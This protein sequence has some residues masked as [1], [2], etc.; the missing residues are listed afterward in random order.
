MPPF[1]PIQRTDLIR[2]LRKAGFTGRILGVSS[3]SA[4]AA[5]LGCGAIDAGAPLAE[6]VPQADLV[7]LSQAIGRIL[8]TVRH[9]DA[10]VKP[11]APRALS[12]KPMK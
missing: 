3:P 12:P 9:I 5:A 10:L 4:L 8:D 1:G 7:F 2:A 11:C 6:A